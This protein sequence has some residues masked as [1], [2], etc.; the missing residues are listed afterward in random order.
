MT[1]Q[2]TLMAAALAAATLA[3]A[4]LAANA[5]TTA[6]CNVTKTHAVKTSAKK[7]VHRTVKRPVAV[8]AYRESAP[9]VRTRTVVETRYVYARPRVIVAPAP[10]YYEPYPVYYHHYVYGGPIYHHYGYYHR[11]VVYHRHW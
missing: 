11:P 6:A 9:T 7:V 10:E 8:A 2:S 1:R 4:P 3:A 5:A